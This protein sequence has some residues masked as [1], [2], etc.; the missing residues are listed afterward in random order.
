MGKLLVRKFEVPIWLA[1]SIGIVLILN[2]ITDGTIPSIVWIAVIFLLILIWFLF[3]PNR[4]RFVLTDTA[5]YTVEVQGVPTGITPK[6]IDMG[7]L[8]EGAELDGVGMIT[9]IAGNLVFEDGDGKEIDRFADPIKLTYTFTNQDQSMLA[10][11]RKFYMDATFV[12]VYLY[13]Y[14]NKEGQL[15][16]IWKPFQNY[17]VDEGAGKI[18][19]EFR[20]WGDRPIGGGTQP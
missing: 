6:M 8:A 4:G 20:V 3:R 10:E 11:R 12:P 5:G 2:S 13:L 9:S 1:T 15:L 18:T 7:T 16:K 17:I 14:T 19:V